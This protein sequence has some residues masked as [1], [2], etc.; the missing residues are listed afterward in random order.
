LVV[1]GSDVFL[2]KCVLNW[3][4]LSVAE[5]MLQVDLSGCTHGSFEVLG[6]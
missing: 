3:L 4:D 1:Y 6:S 2:S 5:V